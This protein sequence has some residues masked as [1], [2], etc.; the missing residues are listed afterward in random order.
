MCGVPA[1]SSQYSFHRE[2]KKTKK[3]DVSRGSLDNQLEE[4]KTKGG[5]GVILDVRNWDV[6]RVE[7][8]REIIDLTSEKIKKKILRVVA[9]KKKNCD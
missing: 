5:E 4:G 2:E 8:E 7:N 9:C 1:G 6:T 3:R